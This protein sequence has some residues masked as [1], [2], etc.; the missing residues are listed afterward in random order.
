MGKIELNVAVD[1][2]LLADARAKGVMIDLAL[3]EG[4]GQPCRE[5]NLNDPWVS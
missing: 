1:A 3:E 5:Q 2:A 4:C